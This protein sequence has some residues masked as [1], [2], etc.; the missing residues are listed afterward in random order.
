MRYVDYDHAGSEAL[1]AELKRFRDVPWRTGAQRMLD[2]WRKTSPNLCILCWLRFMQA[3]E[4]AI[5]DL[6]E[7]TWWGESPRRSVVMRLPY[8]SNGYPAKHFKKRVT[9][10]DFYG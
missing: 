3:S 8:L 10:R 4:K 9:L 5:A 1:D 2:E 7:S 6:R